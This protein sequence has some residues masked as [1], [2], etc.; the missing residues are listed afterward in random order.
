MTSTETGFSS[1]RFVITFSPAERGNS[2]PGG[3]GV[4]RHERYCGP[5]RSPVT[6]WA[7]RGCSSAAGEWM[8]VSFQ[9]KRFD[10][11]E[12]E[13]GG[14][15]GCGARHHPLRKHGQ[16]IWLLNDRKEL[17][18]LQFA[19]EVQGRGRRKQWCVPARADHRG[20]SAA[21]PG[22]RG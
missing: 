6:P 22:H 18:R 1:A 8:G 14:E 12:E 21:W 5:S 7:W 10:R 17:S 2:S 4:Y 13:W 20:R 16:Q 19:A 9:R 11:L 15:V 3:N